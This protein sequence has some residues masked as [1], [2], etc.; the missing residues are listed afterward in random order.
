MRY[1]R[2]IMS[3]TATVCPKLPCTPARSGVPVM[4]GVSPIHT[5]PYFVIV[6]YS[7]AERHLGY[8]KRHPPGSKIS[9][10]P[11]A[12]I[13]LLRSRLYTRHIFF[14]LETQC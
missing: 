8:K 11:S 6:L 1:R 4:R 5:V 12:A 3:D 13:L 14:Q 10:R 9:L 7:G 2:L